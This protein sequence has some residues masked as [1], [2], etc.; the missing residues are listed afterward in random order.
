M[1]DEAI[2]LGLRGLLRPFGAR[3]DKIRKSPLNPPF[4]KGDVDIWIPASAG[5]TRIVRYP[6]PEAGGRGNDNHE[7]SPNLL[8][9][10][11]SVNM[12]G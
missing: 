9:C 12:S 10:R 8:K 3:N 6:P 11:R 4:S 5:M 2:Q 1:D 7:F